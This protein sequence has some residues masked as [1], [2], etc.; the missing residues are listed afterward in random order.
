MIRAMG[1]LVLFVAGVV[2]GQPAAGPRFEVASIKL[3]SPEQMKGPSGCATGHGRVNCSNVTLKR[4]IMGAYRIGP[5]QISGGPDWLDSDH[6]EIVAK[7]EQPA[8]DDGQLM[9]MLQTLLAGRFKLAIHHETRM[10]PAYVLEVG[11]N[12][13]K[14]TQR[15]GSNA[16]PIGR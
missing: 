11:K 8:N 13:P 5:N 12:G 15:V 9:D 14:L 6:Y 7:A 1:V 16:A 4:C 3:T 2:H 10:L